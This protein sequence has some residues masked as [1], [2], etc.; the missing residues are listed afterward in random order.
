MTLPE[1]AR[2]LMAYRFG[3]PGE[4]AYQG[5][6]LIGAALLNLR[7]RLPKVIVDETGQDDGS[8]PHV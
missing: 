2:A 1:A 5:A 3:P 4:E 6:L 7:P 8:I